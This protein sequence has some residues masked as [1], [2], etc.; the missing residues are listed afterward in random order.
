M[1]IA[2]N[3]AI[4][5]QPTGQRE[6]PRV[7]EVHRLDELLDEIGPVVPPLNM[8]EFVPQLLEEGKEPRV[9]LEY[10]GTLLYGLRQMGSGNVLDSLRPLGM[11]VSYGNA[12]GAGRTHQPRRGT[13]YPAE[14]RSGIPDSSS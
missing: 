3:L 9:M 7:K 8:G 1:V 12:S 2:G 6:D 11:M 5:I 14:T 13:G 4:E 10:S